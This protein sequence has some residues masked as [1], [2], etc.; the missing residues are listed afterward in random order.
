MRDLLITVIQILLRNK[1]EINKTVDQVMQTTNKLKRRET[2]QMRSKFKLMTADRRA[3]ANELKNLRIGD[4]NV[5]TRKGFTQYDKATYDRESREL[6]I[7]IEPELE[8]EPTNHIETAVDSGANALAMSSSAAANT[9]WFGP[10]QLDQSIA[11]AGFAEGGHSS[12]P[13]SDGDEYERD[14][15]MRNESGISTT[16]Y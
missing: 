6:S 16:C 5:G 10:D 7:E 13:P 3:V 1:R 15:S 2:E 8:M 4:W 11:E 14:Q 12:L 9:D